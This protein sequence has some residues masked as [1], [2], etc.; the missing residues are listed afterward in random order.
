VFFALGAEYASAKFFAFTGHEHQLGTNVRVWAS[1]SE[2]APGV[3]IYDVQR[4][5]WSEPEMVFHDP[6][7]TVTPGGGFKLQCEWQN[8]TARDVGFDETA[9]GE[10]C[11]FWAY[12]YPSQG[13]RVCVR[14][15][16]LTGGA[17]VCCP[18]DNAICRAV[19]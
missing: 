19:H 4:F 11:F 3:S 15:S 18:G 14:G 6:P 17:T 8:P 7:V 5:S 2:S 1:A 10:M 9:T 16:A 12:Y 13:P